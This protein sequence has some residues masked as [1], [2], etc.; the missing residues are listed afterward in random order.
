M[1][2]CVCWQCEDAQL[3]ATLVVSV[4][5]ADASD[6]HRQA[7]RQVSAGLRP[8][9]LNQPPQPAVA[10]HSP[11][12]SGECIWGCLQQ[13]VRLDSLPAMQALLSL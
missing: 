5:Y 7:P 1:L 11:G 6:V 13:S 8:G 2:L 3:M 10:A 12:A 4:A 9:F